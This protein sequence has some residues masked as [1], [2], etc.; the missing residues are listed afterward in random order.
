MDS[1][2]IPGKLSRKAWSNKTNGNKE[3]IVAQFVA[4][5]KSGGPVTKNQNLCMVYKLEFEEKDGDGYYSD[6]TVDSEGTYHFD[7]NFTMFDTA[8]DDNSNRES[9]VEGSDLNVSAAAA[10]TQ[11][12]SILKQ[13]GNKKK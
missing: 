7:V 4:N 8:A 11:R 10:K 1:K 2:V 12:P 9:V 5:S 3:K 6:C 13:K